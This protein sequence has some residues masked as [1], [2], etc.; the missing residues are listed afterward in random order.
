MESDHPLSLIE[1]AL[2]RLRTEGVLAPNMIYVER[3]VWIVLKIAERKLLRTLTTALTLEQRTRL[4]GHF[5]RIP[6]FAA[7]RV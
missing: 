6:P 7:Q 3:L 1:T 4:D 5:T 2:K